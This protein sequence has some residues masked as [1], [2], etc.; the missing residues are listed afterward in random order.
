M[1]VLKR[2]VLTMGVMEWED[3]IR[4]MLNAWWVVW[5]CV[6]E[7]TQCVY[8]CKVVSGCVRVSVNMCVNMLTWIICW[9]RVYVN[10]GCERTNTDITLIWK[11]ETI[12]KHEDTSSLIECN[13]CTIDHPINIAAHQSVSIHEQRESTS[14]T[15]VNVHRFSMYWIAFKSHSLSTVLLCDVGFWMDCEI[16]FSTVIAS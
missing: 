5:C 13:N 14:F 9:L 11:C 12:G 2:D 16:W 4:W 7:V 10:H 1:C 8:D 15:H 3:L 6:S